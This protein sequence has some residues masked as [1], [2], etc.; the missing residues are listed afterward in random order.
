MVARWLA[1]ALA[2]GV[3]TSVHPR[4]APALHY[5][6]RFNLTRHVSGRRARVSDRTLSLPL[7]GAILPA[8]RSG[9]S[10]TCCGAP[11]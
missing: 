4:A 11:C 6:Q 7:S 8:P 1:A 5:A 9:A 10:S 2:D 3:S